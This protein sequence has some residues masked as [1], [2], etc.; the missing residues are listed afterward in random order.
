MRGKK[1]RL[2]HAASIVVDDEMKGP[3]GIPK[4]DALPLSKNE[5][6]A[7][8]LQRERSKRLPREFGC[9]VGSAFPQTAGALGCRRNRT[10]RKS[11][12]NE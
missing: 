5:I 11:E 3:R 12:G 8:G 10:C 2:I 7:L 6:L 1:G 9:G 4:I